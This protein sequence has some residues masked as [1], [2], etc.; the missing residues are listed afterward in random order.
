MNGYCSIHYDK[1]RL[2]KRIQANF[3][4]SRPLLDGDDQCCGCSDMQ[5]C[6]EFYAYRLFASFGSAISR[7]LFYLQHA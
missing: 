7:V 1:V 3:I 2:A 5:L 6:G 4:F